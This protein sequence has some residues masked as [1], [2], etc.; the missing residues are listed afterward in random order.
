MGDLLTLFGLVLGI[1]TVEST[2]DVRTVSIN[3]VT[4]AE[5]I[6]SEWGYTEDSIEQKLKDEAYLVMREARSYKRASRISTPNAD[7]SI[8]KVARDAGVLRL[9]QRIQQGIGFLE[10][11]VTGDILADR[12]KV[13]MEL[14]AHRFDQQVIRARLERPKDQLD[15]L[16]RDAGWTLVRL[17]DPHIACAALL[18]RSVK[19]GQ[20][21]PVAALR[22]IDE[23]LPMVTTPDRPWLLNLQGVT[24]A[25]L[26]RHAEALATFR[27]AL[28]LQPE[29][30]QAWLNIGTMLAAD[31]R[32]QDAIKA[33]MTA[34][35]YGDSAEHG[36]EQTNSAALVMWALSL[37]KLGRGDEVVPK[38]REAFRADKSY[39]LPVRLLVERV[40]PDSREAA[41]LRKIVAE[42]SIPSG[43]LDWAPVY[44]DNLVGL[45]PV[46]AIFGTAATS[47]GR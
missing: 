9:L 20:A 43:M 40:A 18:R 11:T 27:E 1:I 25:M 47:V 15:Q 34:L 42:L 41:E 39:D 3:R 45:M 46:A 44:T 17:V 14:R 29:F 23:A 38:L 35:S 26:G 2:I 12:G 37:E 4:I 6:R 10:Y 5:G 8:D 32:H 16:M 24:L 19:E 22:C 30:P 7:G 21:N 13:K 28:S 36:S 31:G 33:Y